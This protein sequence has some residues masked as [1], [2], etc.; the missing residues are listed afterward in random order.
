MGFVPQTPTFVNGI[1]AGVYGINPLM[2][3]TKLI[4]FWYILNKNCK[5]ILLL[6]P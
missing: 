2:V 6:L 1:N 5:G 4:L 3:F